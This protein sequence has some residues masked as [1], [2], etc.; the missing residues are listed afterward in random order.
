MIGEVTRRM[1]PHLSG[2][3]HLHEN[4][5]LTYCFFCRSRCCHRCRCLSSLV[6]CW[7]HSKKKSE[8]HATPPAA[9]QNNVLNFPGEREYMGSIS[10]CRREGYGFHAVYSGIGYR[11]QRV[12]LEQGIFFQ[13]P[14][15]IQAKP[16]Q[17]LGSGIP[18][19]RQRMGATF[20]IK[21]V[22]TCNT[23]WTFARRKKIRTRAAGW[24]PLSGPF[25][26]NLFKISWCS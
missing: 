1:L 26:W 21:M 9:H 12:G 10:M 24:D 25:T 13:I 7:G 4:R 14:P 19:Y 15:V 6:A 8:L 16:Q 17:F 11:N 20:N 3:P 5:P 23:H 2:V 18:C 22:T